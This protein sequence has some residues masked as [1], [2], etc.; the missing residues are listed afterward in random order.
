M[1]GLIEA[2]RNKLYIQRGF[3]GDF[4]PRIPPLL[5]S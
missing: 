3:P 4:V 5:D 1:T 2:P